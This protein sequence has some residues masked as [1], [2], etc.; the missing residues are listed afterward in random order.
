MYRK[1]QLEKTRQIICEAAFCILYDYA[2][3]QIIV[4]IVDVLDCS[5]DD[6]SDDE[7]K[8]IPEKEKP[9]LKMAGKIVLLSSVSSLQRGKVDVYTV[10]S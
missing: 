5:R 4:E 10:R 6:D 8:V 9:V 3:M 7:E 1:L 2:I